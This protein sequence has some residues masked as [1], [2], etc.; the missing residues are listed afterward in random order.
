MRLSPWWFSLAVV[1]GDVEKAH[2][3]LVSFVRAYCEMPLPAAAPDL[4]VT[5]PAPPL[6][7]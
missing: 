6:E 4:I 5:R 1:A 2:E 3:Q 7:T